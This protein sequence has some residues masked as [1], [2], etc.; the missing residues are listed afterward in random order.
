MNDREQVVKHLELILG[1]V[2][3]LAQ[4]SF[5]IKGWSMT[6][7][8]VAIIFISKNTTHSE[9]FILV[10][11]VPIIGFWILDGY[12]LWQERLFRGVYDDIR[13]QD[14][15][16]FKMDISAQKKKPRNKWHK[17]MFSLTLNIFYMTEVFF[18]LLVFCTL[19]QDLSIDYCISD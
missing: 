6:L 3:R 19:N 17:A 16:D 11:A 18:V 13:V 12:F 8:T 15:T 1:V 9:F 14:K 7:L 4:N 10:M 2:N 5:W